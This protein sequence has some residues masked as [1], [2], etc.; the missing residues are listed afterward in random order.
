[1]SDATNLEQEEVGFSIRFRLPSLS[2][3]VIDNADRTRHGREILAAQIDTLYAAFSQSREGYH[4]MEFR[5]MSL[6]VDNHVPASIHPVLV[7]TTNISTHLSSPY[8]HTT[9]Q[10]FYPQIDATEPFLHFSAVRRLQ[11]HTTTYVFR[12]AAFR[13]LDVNVFL[14]RR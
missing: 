9:R 2:V 3:S 10:I 13:M 11:E 14:D 7:R 6:Q 4:E 5:L 8:S 12:Y 1:M